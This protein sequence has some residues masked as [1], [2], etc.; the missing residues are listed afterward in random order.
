MSVAN[1]TIRTSHGNIA[2]SET[3][4]S[5]VAVLMLHGNSS[6]KEIFAGQLGS[7]LGD[8]YRLIAMD[9]PGHGASS[10]ALDP[11]RTYSI[12]GFA[13]TAIELLGVMGIERAVVFGWSLGGHVAIEM[14]VRFPGVIGLV[15]TGTPPVSSTLESIQTGFKPNPLVMLIGKEEF[16]DEEA[17]AFG[18][19]TYGALFN[20]QFRRAIKRTDGRLRRMTFENLMAG[21]PADQKAAA[22]N[23][24]MPVAF[25]NGADDPFV[26]L[27]YVGGLRYRSLW[28]DH[29]YVLR[30]LGHVPFLQ[31]PAA[32]NPIFARYLAEVADRVVRPQ[33]AKK[34]S[35]AAA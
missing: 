34:S 23:A 21:G 26:N 10:D 33:K 32:F 5:G 16:S 9:L 35:T 7:D 27:E 24:T 28:D 11:A 15:L 3:S 18:Q 1:K 2:I 22:E 4:G 14:S 25:V 19:G 29:C 31:A 12:P 8:T 13:D 6:A 20:D 17:E 30:G